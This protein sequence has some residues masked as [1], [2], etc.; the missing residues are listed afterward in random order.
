[1]IIGICG[2]SGSGKS[3]LSEILAKKL[4]MLHLDIDKIS[5]EVLGF[6]ETQEFLKSNFSKEIFDNNSLNRKKLGKIVFG[7]PEKLK[8]LNDFCQV[9]IE[10]RI[11]EIIATEKRPIILDYALLDKL[12]QFQCCDVKIL[13]NEKFE[14]RLK[15]VQERENI[16]KEYFLSRDNSLNELD[17]T[18]F[19]YCY[20]SIS[21][22]Q[23]E[24]LIQKLKILKKELLWLE[25]LQ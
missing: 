3:Y 21:E 9:Q 8:L 18:K 11:D 19:D 1:M 2:K 17:A 24:H 15:R 16:T 14:T 13:L 4:D 20:T 23:I 7:N 10:K 12:K 5:H 22:N 6:Q 25:K